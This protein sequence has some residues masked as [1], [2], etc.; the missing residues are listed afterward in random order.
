[1]ADLQDKGQALQTFWSSF[2][3]PAIDEQSSYD[4]DAMKRLNISAPY[5]SYEAATSNIGD[6]VALTATLNYRSSSWAA[7]AQKAE[8]IAAYIGYGGK[9]IRIIGG[10][11]WIKRGNPFSR[12]MIDEQDPDYRR[13]L[14]NITVEYLTAT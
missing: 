12:R 5:I 10:Y 4:E 6:D 3:L 7:A 14:I 1:M 9:L 13:M 2:R 11:M 8:E